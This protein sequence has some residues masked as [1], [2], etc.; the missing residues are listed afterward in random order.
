MWKYADSTHC[1]LPHLSAIAASWAAAFPSPLVCVLCWMYHYVPCPHNLKFGNSL[2][3]L[4]HFLTAFISLLPE[5]KH[6]GKRAPMAKGQ[7][8]EEWEKL[9]F[10]SAIAKKYKPTK[11]TLQCWLTCSMIYCFCIKNIN[12]FIK[13]RRNYRASCVSFWVLAPVSLNGIDLLSYL[14]KK[15]YF[16]Q[17]IKLYLLIPSIQWHIVFP[18]LGFSFG[19]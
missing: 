3:T 15:V 17:T 5:T 11:L 4:A 12:V 9:V 10:S 2:S 18:G 6:G 13:R 16:S 7:G 14:S 19:G 8:P 1:V